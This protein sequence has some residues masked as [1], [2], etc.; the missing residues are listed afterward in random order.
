MKSFFT[1]KSL[2]VVSAFF[3]ASIVTS[4]HDE[5][6]A[7][8]EELSYRHGYEYNFVKTFGEISPNQSWDFSSYARRNRNIVL[9]RAATVNDFGIQFDSDGYFRVPQEIHDWVF[10]NVMEENGMANNKERIKE[11]LWH[12]FSFEADNTEA[13]DLL[14][15]YLG[16][17]QSS[18]TFHMVVVDPETKQVVSDTELWDLTEDTHMQWTSKGGNDKWHDI[19][20]STGSGGHGS[21]MQARTTRSKP[22]LIDFSD[23]KYRLTKDNV[24][25]TVYFTI[26][27]V[28]GHPQIN[29]DGEVLTSITHT[30]NVVAVN[31]PPNIASYTNGEGYEGMLF[32]CET[33]SPNKIERTDYDFNDL[34][35]LLV[36]RIPDVYY[37]EMLQTTTIK[38]RYMIEDLTGFDFDFNDIVVDLTD[39]SVHYYIIDE[40]NGIKEEKSIVY[41]NVSYPTVTQKA[42]FVYCCGTLPFQVKIGD[43]EFNRVTD[44]TDADNTYKQLSGSSDADNTKV[45]QL[46]SSTGIEPG[47]S[48]TYE[49]Q[50]SET[51]PTPTLFWNPDANNISATIWTERDL[52]GA[53]DSSAGVDGPWAWVSNFP[54]TG[55]VPFIIA[56]DQSV[57]WSGEL[58]HVDFNW[59]GGDMS[60]D[61]SYEVTVVPITTTTNP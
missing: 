9:T 30:P 34:M 49:Y 44:P 39:I 27:V 4:C 53:T 32:G 5:E 6:V 48:F 28:E 20:G 24:K 29:T 52:N 50:Y 8:V 45:T 25:Y 54:N 40:D 12:A 18:Y 17:S 42:S 31:M 36:G 35:F 59:L 55:D 11:S 7:N 23:P 57:N 2:A 13:F 43:K 37:D 21:T 16:A 60:T 47:Y 1:R 14:P 3:V 56:T 10:N 41:N 58:T 22:I 61:N 46:G 15:F 33:G 19:E 51:S 26:N 38:K